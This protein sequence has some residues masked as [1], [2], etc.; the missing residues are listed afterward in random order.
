VL[1]WNVLGEV[2]TSTD[3]A[4]CGG[5]GRVCETAPGTSAVCND[6]ECAVRCLAGRRDC[7][8]S[9]LDGCEVDTNTDIANCGSCGHICPT[10][11]GFEGVTPTCS[12]GVCGSECSA[13]R[14]DCNN[15]PLD[16]CEI[17]TNTNI[18]HCGACG[19]ECPIYD[20]A[21]SLCI[22]G[23]CAPYCEQPNGPWQ[24]CDGDWTNGCEMN[25]FF[26]NANCGAC[27]RNCADLVQPPNA[28]LQCRG[29]C[30]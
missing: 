19:A 29:G 10:M 23:T 1:T 14:A 13:G 17:D 22:M 20:H 30:G 11:E 7:N 27:G 6:D 5:C 16:G 18:Y 8:N 12:G 15:N 25:T 2:D 28:D 9:P 24:N 4:N 26:N 3:P 21:R